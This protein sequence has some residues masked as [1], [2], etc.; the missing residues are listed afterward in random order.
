MFSSTKPEFNVRM[1][2]HEY[3][4]GAKNIFKYCKNCDFYNLICS[5]YI[6]HEFSNAVILLIMES[7]EC[8]LM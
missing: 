4:N 1:H 7:K 6:R 3:V 5:S 8:S 2:C